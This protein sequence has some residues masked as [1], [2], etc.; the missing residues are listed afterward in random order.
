VFTGDW[1]A[2]GDDTLGLYRPGNGTIYLR[3]TNT[4]GIADTAY[5][6][7]HSGHRPV[8]GTP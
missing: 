3:N 6:M 4:T 1:D 7:G 8:A 2:D 5:A